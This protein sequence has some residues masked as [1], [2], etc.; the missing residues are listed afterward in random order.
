MKNKINFGLKTNTSP[1]PNEICCYLN[2]LLSIKLKET[3]INDVYKLCT[4][5]HCSIK[6]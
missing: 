4:K 5:G 2:E 6:I 1:D 3:D